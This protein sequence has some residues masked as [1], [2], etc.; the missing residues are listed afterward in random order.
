AHNE[1][2][3]E[4]LS[5]FGF[6]E[7]ETVAVAGT[8]LSTVEAWSR[9]RGCTAV[10]GPVNPSL[11]ESAGL[12]IEGFDDDPCLLMPY[13]PPR[14]AAFIESHGYVK[15][16]DLLGWKLDLCA[17]LGARIERLADRLRRRRRDL[18]V[19]RVDLKAFERDLALMNGIYRSAW[20][21]NWGFV[22][23]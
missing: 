21:D 1:F 12:L 23:P 15:V 16:K 17:P 6:F 22:P 4:R 9:A 10:R 20:Q 14:Y 2:H 18:T 3:R 13:N 19:R 5:W 8:L 7:A 11:N